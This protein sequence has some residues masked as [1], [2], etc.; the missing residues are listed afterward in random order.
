MAEPEDAH[1]QTDEEKYQQTQ[2]VMQAVV[3]MYAD[4]K[5][6]D[7]VREAGRSTQQQ[8]KM[9]GGDRKNEILSAI[10]GTAHAPRSACASARSHLGAHV[11]LWQSLRA[12]RSRSSSSSQSSRRLR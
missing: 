7:M 11:S 1:A 5:D 6:Q 9:V 8:Q 10:R 2:E 3:A 12:R 4:T